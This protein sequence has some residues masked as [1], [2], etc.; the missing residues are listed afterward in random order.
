MATAGTHDIRETDTRP[1]AESQTSQVFEGER[2]AEPA[3]VGTAAEAM[4]GIAAAVLSIIG[5]SFVVPGYLAA[6]AAI[7][8]GA[9]FMLR[10][11]GMVARFSSLL[12]EAPEAHDGPAPFASLM[13]AEGFG[14]AAGIV[15]GILSLLGLIPAVLLSATAVVFGALLVVSTVASL[16]MRAHLLFRNWA[17]PERQP[18]R[19]LLGEMIPGAGGAQVLVGI[20]AIV[21]GIIGLVGVYPIGVALVAFLCLGLL[22]AVSSMAL[23]SKLMN[24]CQR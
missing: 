4:G 13:S 1:L 17:G 7:T 18:N 24:E 8:L 14:G 21:L 2:F 11:S 6:I 10:G 20:A 12:A 15:L 3:A 9:A 16:R 22:V 5:L 19:P 23:N